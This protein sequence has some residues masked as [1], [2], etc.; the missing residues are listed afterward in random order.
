M[1]YLFLGG[2]LLV[3]LFRKSCSIAT[4]VAFQTVS[5][6]IAPVVAFQTVSCGIAA[7]VAFQ[8]V[9]LWTAAECCSYF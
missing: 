7:V 9:C 8:T 4:V 6:S 1:L 5:C 2:G 3:W